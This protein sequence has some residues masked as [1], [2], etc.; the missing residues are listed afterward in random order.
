MRWVLILLLAVSFG[1]KKKGEVSATI[2]DEEKFWCRK[3][4][5]DNDP[6]QLAVFPFRKVRKLHYK[7]YKRWSGGPHMCSFNQDNREPLQT[8]DSLVEECVPCK[9]KCS[10]FHALHE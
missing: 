7:P 8:D 6:E 10:Y 2:S 5:G 9:G 1:S 3:N 4:L